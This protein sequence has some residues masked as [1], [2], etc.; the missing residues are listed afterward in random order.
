MKKINKTAMVNTNGGVGA[1]PGCGTVGLA[2]VF[3][4]VSGGI[5][6]NSYSYWSSLWTVCWNMG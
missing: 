2:T 3:S 6:L 5:G 1:P 4:G